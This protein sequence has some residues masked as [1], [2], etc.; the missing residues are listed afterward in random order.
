MTP[1][2]LPLGYTAVCRIDPVCFMLNAS[3]F[4]GSRSKLMTKCWNEILKW[5][6]K[7]KGAVVLVA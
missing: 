2:R 7:G 1:A 5:V 3:S 6:V 4:L